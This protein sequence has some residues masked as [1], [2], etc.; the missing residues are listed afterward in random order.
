MIVKKLFV[1]SLLLTLIM[2][3]YLI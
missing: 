2:N 3:Y 1:Y